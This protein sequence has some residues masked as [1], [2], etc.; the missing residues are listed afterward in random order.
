MA[1]EKGIPRNSYLRETLNRRARSLTYLRPI[2][3][4]EANKGRQVDLSLGQYDLFRLTSTILD[5]IITEMGGFQQGAAYE[6]ILEGM[7]QQ[8][9]AINP[10][11]D[12]VTVD[13]ITSFILDCLT[14]EKARD[15]FRMEYQH[16]AEN[17]QI[18]W[19]PL[20]FKLVELRDI[21]GTTEERYVAKPE[22]INIYLNS[23]SVDLEGQQAADEAALTH[24]IKHGKFD[25]AELSARTASMRTTEY[26]DRIKMA[27]RLVERGVSDL[28]WVA[29]IIPKINSARDHIEERLRAENFLVAEAER[30]IEEADADG[31]LRLVSIID[32]IRNTSR[33]HEALLN[34]VLRANSQFLVEH[35][36]RKFRPPGNLAYPQP[37]SDVL[38]P[39]LRLSLGD[40]DAWIDR[41]WFQL[42]P[43]RAKALADFSTM[44]RT[45][46]SPKREYLVGGKQS[47][48]PEF[49]EAIENEPPFSADAHES[50]E[51]V[52]DQM[53]ERFHLSEFIRRIGSEDIEACHLSMI[54]I[55]DWYEGHD[56]QATVS[57]TG[58]SFINGATYG[59]D[60]VVV[61]P[62]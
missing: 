26:A 16:E 1:L 57:A 2:F 48:V 55:G 14:N 30:K 43:P 53:P 24:F 44:T 37:Q 11:I 6:Q 32:L 17:G 3:D 8:I 40:F 31:R 39:L 7:V 12:R 49:E 27:L 54:K 51:R 61:K 35:A 42:H 9:T 10:S 46:L 4:L 19:R 38:R 21:E 62:K 23:L 13:K 56:D 58:E 20:V 60:L 52:M 29:D 25:E 18:V 5:V 28:D 22:A 45:L 47:D 50:F 41:F 36:N 59:D 34:I 15:S 33:Q